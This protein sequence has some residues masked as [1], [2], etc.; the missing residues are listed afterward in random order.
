ME[1]RNSTS[2]GTARRRFLA[3]GG[4]LSLFA[5]LKLW[6]VP[7]KT[8]VIDCGPDQKEETV[9]L[10]GQDGRLVEV[11]ASRLKMLQKKITNDELQNWVRRKSTNDNHSTT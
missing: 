2:A 7:R 5:L 10:L 3:A 4:I 8:P 6:R 1:E 9:R 11:N